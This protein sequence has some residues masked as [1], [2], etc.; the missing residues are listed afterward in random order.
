MMQKVDKVYYAALRLGIALLENGNRQIQASFYLRFSNSDT[1][2]FFQN[3]REII[4]AG[5]VHIAGSNVREEQSVD[6]IGL[7]NVKYVKHTFRMLQ[8]FCEHH[9]VG[10]QNFLRDQS[11]QNK[12]SH[13]MVLATLSF[14]DW[15]GLSL[16]ITHDNSDII[17]QA[18]QT[19]TEYCQGPCQENQDCIASYETN[20]I[21]IIVKELLLVESSSNQATGVQVGAM[22]ELFVELR[23]EAAIMLSSLMESRPEED[24]TVHDRILLSMNGNIQVL[25]DT[26]VTLFVAAGDQIPRGTDVLRGHSC[27]FNREVGHVLYLLAVTLSGHKAGLMKTL[28]A[29]KINSNNYEAMRVFATPLSQDGESD[30]LLQD[31]S[32]PPEHKRSQAAVAF[33]NVEDK[34]D[35]LFTGGVVGIGKHVQSCETTFALDYYAMHTNKIEIYRNKKLETVVFPVPPVCCYLTLGSRNTV[36]VET[37]I[38]N[39]GSKVPAFFKKSI[40]LQQEMMWQQKLT[41]SKPFYKMT[42]NMRMWQEIGEYVYS[43][44]ST[45][46]FWLTALMPESF[47]PCVHC[48]SRLHATVRCPSTARNHFVFIGFAVSARRSLSRCVP[49]RAAS[50]VRIHATNPTA[51][52]R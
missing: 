42:L 4:R 46:T 25:V 39:E 21:D 49:S 31:S 11:S 14:L 26:I 33:F 28:N 38:D 44:H 22:E 32:T 30:S 34:V 12:I 48:G 1:S 37:L 47:Q 45:Y 13:N 40:H 7:A 2:Q 17:T 10:M 8:L 50:C 35:R 41:A 36:E 52:S 20:G 15:Y 51:A 9:H 23:H 29:G 19:L 27:T 3:M 24:K 43:S 5:R 16:A 6:H 18:L